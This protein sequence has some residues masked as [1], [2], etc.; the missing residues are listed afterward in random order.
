MSFESDRNL[1]KGVDHILFYDVRGLLERA[2][3]DDDFG[4][5]IDT[6]LEYGSLGEV[7]SR[8]RLPAP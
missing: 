3:S 8:E 6:R 2:Q 7:R 4:G 5:R 1:D